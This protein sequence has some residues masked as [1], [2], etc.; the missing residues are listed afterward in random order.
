MRL[1]AEWLALV[2]ECSEFAVLWTPGVLGVSVVR[3]GHVTVGRL[4][5]CEV[6]MPRDWPVLRR[7]SRQR[8]SKVHAGSLLGSEP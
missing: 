7:S 3:V 8:V 2:G 4:R 6:W 5:R 1:L